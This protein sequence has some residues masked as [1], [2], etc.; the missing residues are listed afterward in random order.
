MTLRHGT[1]KP[2]GK[3]AISLSPVL[4]RDPK[5][6]KSKV[7]LVSTAGDTLCT[8]QNIHHKVAQYPQYL[9]AI[10]ELAV[11]LRLRTT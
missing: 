5:G 3:A 1:N 11:R 4:Y 8:C 2:I 7:L 10:R 9:P 6:V